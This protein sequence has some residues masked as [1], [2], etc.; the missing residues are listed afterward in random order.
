MSRCFDCIISRDCCDAMFQTLKHCDAQKWCIYCIDNEVHIISECAHTRAVKEC[1]HEIAEDLE[2]TTSSLNAIL[3]NSATYLFMP[4]L[5]PASFY[6][7]AKKKGVSIDIA[8]V[9]SANNNLSV[10]TNDTN[11]IQIVRR[12]KGNGAWLC[13]ATSCSGLGMQLTKQCRH[14]VIVQNHINQGINTPFS[15]IA[16]LQRLKNSI[17]TVPTDDAIKVPRHSRRMIPSS[18]AFDIDKEIQRN[19][20]AKQ[21]CVIRA[22]QSCFCG[23]KLEQCSSA[24]TNEIPLRVEAARHHVN[25]LQQVWT[26]N[27]GHTILPEEDPEKRD[28]LVWISRHTAYSEVFLFDILLHIVLGT[29]IS[30]QADIRS[31]MFFPQQNYNS[32]QEVPRSPQSVRKAL[33]IY[34]M[35]VVMRMEDWVYRCDICAIR[36]DNGF[37]YDKISFDGQQLGFKLT[38]DS[39]YEFYGKKA[40]T[41][42]RSVERCPKA[43]QMIHLIESPNLQ[44]ILT[45]VCRV[46]KAPSRCTSV[47]TL[48]R[49]MMNISLHQRVHTSSCSSYQNA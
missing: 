31:Q 28:G 49:S 37:Y 41:W 35:S 17:T 9:R 8:V 45:E 12:K 38:H 21:T 3:Q 47:N 15:S 27:E 5:S 34:A 22:A 6:G 20:L 2:L 32:K 7:D 33:I 44:G 42:R 46:R 13:T 10:V 48:C 11:R 43:W 19:A 30:S 40:F 24:A 29:T 1:I 39:R 25:Y 26:C 4:D 16:M 23:E 36:E 18:R 14:A